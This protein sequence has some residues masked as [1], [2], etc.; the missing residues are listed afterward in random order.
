VRSADCVTVTPVEQLQSICIA[1][2]QPVNFAICYEE[3]LD[4]PTKED[5]KQYKYSS[6]IYLNL[7][8]F[9]VIYSPV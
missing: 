4:N 3:F 1:A 9:P 6:Y 2:C 5:S 8:Y 7:F